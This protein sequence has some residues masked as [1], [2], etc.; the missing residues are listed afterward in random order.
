MQQLKIN[1]LVVKRTIFVT[2]FIIINTFFMCIIILIFFKG[3][4]FHRESTGESQVMSNL[5]LN[6]SIT[7]SFL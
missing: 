7:D 1:K 4:E 3:P 2:N 5:L 6:Y